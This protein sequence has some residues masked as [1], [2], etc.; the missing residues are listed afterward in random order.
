[1]VLLPGVLLPG[2]LIAGVL[3]AGVLLIRDVAAT[4]PIIGP[5]VT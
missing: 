3:I 4:V 5:T 2:V 1:V